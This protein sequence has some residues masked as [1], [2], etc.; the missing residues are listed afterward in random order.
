MLPI[1]KD[2]LDGPSVAVNLAVV[3]AWAN[4]L[5]LAFEVLGSLTKA[6]NGPFYG[7]L[8]L[9]SY[10]NPLRKGPRFE[11]LLNELAPRD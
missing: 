2:A 11:K 7:D 3:Y 1:S 8:K 5:D 9:S 10:F 6:P 4:E